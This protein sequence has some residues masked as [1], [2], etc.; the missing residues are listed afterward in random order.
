MPWR[1]VPMKDVGH[2]DKLRLAVNRRLTRRFPNGE[3]HC[4]EPAVSSVEYI[5]RMKATWGTETSKY[6]EEKRPFP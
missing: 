6:P 2:C 5:D 3:T 1:Q 4:G